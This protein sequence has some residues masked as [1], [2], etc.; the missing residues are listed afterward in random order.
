MEDLKLS[1]HFHL[2]EFTVSETAARMGRA[3]EVVPGDGIFEALQA[4]CENV[5]DPVRERFGKLVVS[6]GY[7]PPWLNETLPGTAHASQHMKGEAADFTCPGH[8]VEE[9]TRWVAQESALPFDQLIYE[10][11]AWTHCSYAAAPRGSV[12]TARHSP[13]GTRYETGIV[14]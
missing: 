9:V 2:S 8:S 10:F 12:L 14:I 3:I 11:G 6:S 4:L 5:L 1:K 13:E 7:R